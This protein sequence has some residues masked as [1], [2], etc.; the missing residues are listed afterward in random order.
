MRDEKLLSTP[1]EIR[2]AAKMLWE[3]G[4]LGGENEGDLEG[5]RNWRNFEDY[6]KRRG[7]HKRHALGDEKKI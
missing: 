7:R 2:Q 5:R 1:L 3:M 4:S 6:R